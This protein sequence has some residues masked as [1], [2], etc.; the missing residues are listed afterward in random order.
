VAWCYHNA[1]VSPV[2][3]TC[4]EFSPNSFH[5]NP[6][7]SYAEGHVVVQLVEAL[8]YKLEGHGIDSPWCHWN[9]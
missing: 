5:K 7:K 1:E 4:Q 2:H 3:A 6:K 9:F 8:H